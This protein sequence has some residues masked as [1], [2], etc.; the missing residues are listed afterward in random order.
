[1]GGGERGRWRECR[2]LDLQLSKWKVQ[3]AEEVSVTSRTTMPLLLTSFTSI[4]RQSSV[5][6]PAQPSQPLATNSMF[7]EI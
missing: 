7:T 2:A 4:G 1:V 6:L 5:V 3:K